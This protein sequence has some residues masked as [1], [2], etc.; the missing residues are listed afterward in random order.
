MVNEDAAPARGKTGLV[1]EGFLERMVDDSA[2]AMTW[3]CSDFGLQMTLDKD[4]PGLI[5]KD[6]DQ[7]CIDLAKQCGH[8]FPDLHKNAI[9]AIHPGGPKI[10][11]SIQKLLKLED[12]QVQH[13]RDALKKYGNMS[14]AT[15][16]H[17]LTAI[18]EDQNIPDGTP[19]V[20]MA[21][22][23]GLTMFGAVFVKGTK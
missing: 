13:S 12:H 17:I 5:A 20:S 15:V 21:F 9:F 10:I 22:G 18:I 23:P 7:F 11:A 3:V 1:V 14:S 4:V 6:I 19:V 8:Q 2:H 16:P